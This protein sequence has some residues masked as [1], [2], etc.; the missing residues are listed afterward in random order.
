MIQSAQRAGEE[1]YFIERDLIENKMKLMQHDT[2]EYRKYKQELLNIEDE[3]NDKVKKRQEDLFNEIAQ[4]REENAEKRYSN[5]LLS[6]QN[7]IDAIKNKKESGG[8]GRAPR[9]HG[10]HAACGRAH[11]PRWDAHRRAHPA[12]IRNATLEDH[13]RSVPARNGW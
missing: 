13:G 4:L 12:R 9:H 2:N 11:Q 10:H 6:V 3:F 1:T 7:K 5:E 8:R